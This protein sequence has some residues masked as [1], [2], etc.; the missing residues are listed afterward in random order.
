[1]LRVCI[2][3]RGAES[4]TEEQGEAGSAGGQLQELVQPIVL[5]H[6]RLDSFGEPN[7]R[8][9]CRIWDRSRL[10]KQPVL[11]LGLY[12]DKLLL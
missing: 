5:A 2:P 12:D 10:E 3:A 8:V 7:L 4:E 11:V 1:M 9:P 6:P